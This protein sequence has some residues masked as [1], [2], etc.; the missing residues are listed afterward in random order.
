[1]LPQGAFLFNS[2]GGAGSGSYTIDVN[3][4]DTSKA[5]FLAPGDRITDISGAFYDVS[6][7]AIYPSN[8]GNNGTVTVVPV[9]ADIAPDN[10]L[11][12]GDASVFTPGQIDLAPQ[13]QT[14]GSISSS[15][16]VEG[17]TYKYQVS[18]GFFIGSE[19]N[20]ALVGDRLIDNTGKVFEVTA[21]SGQPGA[22]SFPFDVVEADKVGD[23]PNV[24]GCY[25]YRPT[26]NKRFYQGE[27]LNP[28]AEDEVRNRDELLTDLGFDAG[29]VSIGSGQIITIS[30][31]SGNVTSDSTLVL[32]TES[33]AATVALQGPFDEG[34]IIHIK[35]AYNGTTDR[36]INSITILPPSG[37]TID[38]SASTDLVNANQS[39]TLIRSSGVW[40][41]A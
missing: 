29:A 2:S 36:G 26:P 24:G 5:Q 12:L 10:S 33:G 28:L 16:L 8:F 19:A 3:F 35:D 18:A 27:E 23:A 4:S 21:L 40:Y 7:W 32:V 1:M 38:F 34:K 13:V 11:S 14:G 9:G 22:F 39:S 20:K 31:S 25:L 17:R 15:A 37:E 30:T 6:T 41:L